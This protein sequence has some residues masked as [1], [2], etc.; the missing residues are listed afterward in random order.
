[1]PCRHSQFPLW[2]EGS[3]SWWYF[4]RALRE[5]SQWAQRGIAGWK[6]LPTL[7]CDLILGGDKLPWPEPCLGGQQVKSTLQTPVQE[8]GT[9]PCGRWRRAWPQSHG[10]YLCR[11]A[12]GLGQ[13]WDECRLP[14][15]KPVAVSR[16]LQDKDWPHQLCGSQGRFTAACHSPLPLWTLLRSR[17]S[18]ILLYTLPQWTEYHPPNFSGASACPAQGESECRAT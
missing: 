15:S 13:V 11:D 3:H 9:W 6:K 12:A 1:M 14:G 4:T 8:L 5:V 7:F 2:T 16:A 18:Y 10:C 17:G